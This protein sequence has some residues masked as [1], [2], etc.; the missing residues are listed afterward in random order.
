M[1]NASIT[2]GVSFHSAAAH[3]VAYTP[4]A[5]IEPPTLYELSTGQYQKAQEKKIGVMPV[6]LTRHGPT[7]LDAGQWQHC[8]SG[9]LLDAG[10]AARSSRTREANS[11][12]RSYS[13]YSFVVSTMTSMQASD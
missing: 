6:L 1:E 9:K 5:K 4:P 3:K 12:K 11:T 13:N 8:N 10:G 7:T 2:H